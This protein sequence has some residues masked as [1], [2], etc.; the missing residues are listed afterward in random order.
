MIVDP[1]ATNHCIYKVVRIS[2]YGFSSTKN[3]EMELNDNAQAGW[4]I[5][6]IIPTNDGYWYFVYIGWPMGDPLPDVDEEVKP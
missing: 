4:Q 2:D 1:N 6:K 3:F 5:D